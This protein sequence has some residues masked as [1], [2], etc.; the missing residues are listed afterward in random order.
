MS[1]KS[2]QSGA[3]RQKKYLKNNKN[4]GKFRKVQTVAE[5]INGR[6]RRKSDGNF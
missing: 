6:K 1:I 3:R 4:R 2:Y 5:K